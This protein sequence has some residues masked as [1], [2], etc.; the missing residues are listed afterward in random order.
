MRRFIFLCLL[1]AAAVGCRTNGRPD[2]GCDVLRIESDLAQ[3]VN[4]DEIFSSVNYVLPELNDEHPVGVVNKALIRGGIIFM[5]DGKTLFQYDMN[6]KYVR[7]LTRMGRGP[8]EYL[9]IADFALYDDYVYIIDRNMKILK[10]TVDN[11]FVSAAKLDF[12]PASVY[13]PDADNILLTSAYQS[14]VDKFS[15]YDSESLQRK[16][17]FQPVEK[18]EM[19]YRHITGQSN[20]YEYAGRLLYHEPM[21]DSVYEIDVAGRT[22]IEKLRF[23]LFG[24]NPP[25]SFWQ[26]E[27]ESVVD[28]NIAAVDRG[29]CFGLP[30]WA[31]T[32][33]KMLF[34]YRDGANYRMCLYDRNSGI[35]R[36]FNAIALHEAVPPVPVADVAFCFT[37]KDSQCIV[38]PEES[39]CDS[40][41]RMYVDGMLPDKTGNG[42]PVIA[43]VRLR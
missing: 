29:Y 17:S 14:D 30:V 32:D 15:V 38:F 4:I 20:F 42:N 3:S 21:N 13:V 5:S 36:Q 40:D 10:Y 39:F 31:V 25:D 2:S 12:F 16:T 11:K 18:A 28:I 23:D 41:G 19:T 43:V 27:Y 8:Q 35:S 6:G 37:D 24:K 26:H 22:Y 34:T 33:R 1:A 7:S 9:G